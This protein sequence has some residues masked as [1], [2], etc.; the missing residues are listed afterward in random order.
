MRAKIVSLSTLA[1]AMLIVPVLASAQTLFRTLTDINSLLNGVMV[2]LITL[3]IVVFFWGLIKYIFNREGGGKDGAEGAPLMIWGIAA[4]FVMLSIWGIIALLR[5]TFGVTANTGPIPQPPG[6]SV[7]GG[8][9]QQV[10]G[11]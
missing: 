4:F 7:V 8:L 3:A 6:Q 5:N 9:I 2:L 11:R 10:F 1:A